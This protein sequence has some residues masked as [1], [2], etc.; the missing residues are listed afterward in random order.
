MILKLNVLI[1]CSGKSGILTV[2][3]CL[4]W[5][6]CVMVCC[7]L[8]PVAAEENACLYGGHNYSVRNFS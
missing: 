2:G 3:I 8:Y 5:G 1:L 4:L 7:I 6:M